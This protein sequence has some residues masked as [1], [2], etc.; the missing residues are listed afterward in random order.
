MACKLIWDMQNWETDVL[1]VDR[2]L[3]CHVM[4]WNLGKVKENW[5]EN[6]VP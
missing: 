6:A 3:S 4:G 5:N 1:M 2:D